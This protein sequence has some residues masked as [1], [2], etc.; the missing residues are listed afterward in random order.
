MPI[1]TAAFLRAVLPNEGIYCCFIL[2]DKRHF[3]TRDIDE[4]AEVILREDAL[5]KTVYHGC[6]SYKSESKRSKSNVFHLRSLW[7][8]V[9]AGP[10]KEYPNALV[11]Y[12]EC[13]SFRTLVGLPKPLYV[14]SGRGLH[15]YWPLKHDLSIVEWSVYALALKSHCNDNG[16]HAGPE[17][18][19]DAAS[20][21]RPV[22]THHRK[23][24]ELDVVCDKLVG[25]YDLGL[26]SSLGARPTNLFLDGNKKL[27]SSSK[28]PLAAAAAHIADYAP[29]DGNQVADQCG[30]LGRMRSLRG[31]ISEPEWKA[32]INVLAF[33]E[34]GRD[35]VH[36]WS[37]GDERYNPAETDS[38]FNRGEELSGPTTCEYFE[39]LNK[40]CKQCPHRGFIVSPVELGRGAPKLA[41]EQIEVALQ[42]AEAEDPR[43]IKVGGFQ[44]NAGALAYGED[45]K[46]GKPIFTIVTQYPVYVATVNRGELRDDSH[47]IVLM[48]KM[49][50]ENWREVELPLKLLFGSSGISEI[51]GKGI[52]VHHPDLFRKFVRE[53][54]DLL[55]AKGKTMIQYEQFGWK[56]DESS[57]LVG[58]KLYTSTKVVDVD[59]APEVAKRARDLGP[60]ARGSVEGWKEAADKLFAQ[61]VEAQGFALLSSFAAPLMRFHA[62]DEG[63]AIVSV[64][65]AKSGVGKSTALA[66]AASVWGRLVGL[67][68]TNTDTKVAKGITLGVLGSLP[69]IFDEL[70]NRDPETI[71][72][73]AQIFTTG[74]DK[75][76][77]TGDG[78]LIHSANSWQTIMITGSNL[79]LVDTLKSAR[80]GDAMAMRVIEFSVDLPKTIEH[81]QGDRL[82]DQLFANA[83][84]AGDAY[85]R[86]LVQPETLAYVKAALPKIRDEIIKKHRF[87]SE[88]RF[89]VR[90]LASVSVAAVIV[91]HLGLISFSPDRIV[92]WAIDHLTNRN[93]FSA[94]ELYE[95]SHMLARFLSAN[96]WGTLVMPGPYERGKRQMP[97]IKEPTRDL[98][99]RYEIDGGKIYIEERELRSWMNK[100]GVSWQDLMGELEQ[101][102][103]LV[104]S[105]RLSTLGAGTHYSHGQ[106]PCLIISAMHPAMSGVLEDVVKVVQMGELKEMRR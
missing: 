39:T 21:L 27:S 58:R 97:A 9:D 8:D 95:G 48:H 83:G 14:G 36:L 19:A 4:L 40:L 81:G 46:S 69:V 98:I 2:P 67:Q 105:H 59:G 33:T 13:E 53:S 74:R 63:G 42:F 64:H 16:F 29:S 44:Y 104:A 62:H 92:D 32:C 5:G 70:N 38:K 94:G 10:E 41:K 55:H 54:I 37:T 17:R 26:F 25:P 101:K 57:F 28:A 52:I 60:A 65:S 68:M 90:T 61:G 11:A 31:F 66:A 56:D 71:R 75:L 15:V 86:A 99:I 12:K 7:L 80:A 79:S 22:G 82:K 100:E 47:S 18:T 78:Q 20:I 76:R 85:I 88:H 30:Q 50:H 35:L 1:T 73:F 93:K 43:L 89:W 45:D 102:G 77:G 23:G 34:T 84:H 24:E 72:E 6:A 96:L 87:S 3:W 51:I 103:I 91:K 49:P 106:T